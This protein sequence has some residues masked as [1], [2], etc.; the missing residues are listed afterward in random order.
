[1]QL[2][3]LNYWSIKPLAKKAPTASCFLKRENLET[4]GKLKKL[5]VGFFL[6]V[7]NSHSKSFGP[8]TT[9][10]GGIAVI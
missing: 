7:Y 4:H 9:V 8:Y 3:M 5:N 6:Y 1:M 2:E 10:T